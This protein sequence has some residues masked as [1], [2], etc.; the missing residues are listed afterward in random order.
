MRAIRVW[1]ATAAVT[2]LALPGAVLAPVA[3]AACS[4]PTQDRRSAV[5]DCPP[6]GHEQIFVV[7]NGVRSLH[8]VAVG[9]RGGGGSAGQGLGLGGG[10]G[11]GGV[12]VADVAVTPGRTLYVLVG[13]M[14]GSAEPQGGPGGFNGGG[15]GGG[16][17]RG[18][19]ASGGGGGGASDV[20]TCAVAARRC[21]TLASRLIVAGG[22]G[23][24][25]GGGNLLTG[26]GAG[27]GGGA[28]ADGTASAGQGI[29][30]GGGAKVA[31]G[32]AGGP[33]AAA[34]R[35]GVGGAGGGGTADAGGGGGG[36]RYGGGGGAM[37]AVGGPG[38][39]GGGAG[40]SFGPSAARFG[41]SPAPQALVRITYRSRST[42][43]PPPA[44]RIT[45]PR[46][47]TS[48]SG[49]GLVVSGRAIDASG[50]RG[51]ALRIQRLPR[52]TG[53]CTWLDPVSGLGRA[54][55]EAPPSL[56]A[57]LRSGDT[58]TYRVPARIALSRGRY[59]VTAYGTDETGIYGNS[60][61]ASMRSVTF[62]VRR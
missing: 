41:M 48:V 4:P 53:R 16:S 35:L 21:D 50:V 23:G 54:S 6:V 26:M 49:R 36:G 57:T 19:F 22:G 43:N 30:A 56:L 13:G 58:W 5:V 24:G 59:R 51:V 46:S 7:P 42:V 11:T 29:G 32:G 44:V 45:R 28:G 31:K 33:G 10:G 8:V 18:P 39:S 2:G 15:P 61:R 37:V 55:C 40:S 12:A 34:G 17:P 3:R 27:A 9:A 1:R 62:R 25:G 60:A 47:G 20:R 14:G 38:G 52:A